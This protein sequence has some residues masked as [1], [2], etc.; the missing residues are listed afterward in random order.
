MRF[1]QSLLRGIIVIIFTATVVRG[2]STAPTLPSPDQ[3]REHYQEAA[4]LWPTIP[5]TVQLAFV[6]A[7]DRFFFERPAQNSTITRQIGRWYL[8]PRA[9]NLQEWRFHL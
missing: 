1:F 2:D 4:T 7:E 3:I 9:G 5:R 6:A 8:Q